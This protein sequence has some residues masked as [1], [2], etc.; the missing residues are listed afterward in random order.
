MSGFTGPSL[1]R[2]HNLVYYQAF[3]VSTLGKLKLIGVSPHANASLSVSSTPHSAPSFPADR[4][5]YLAHKARLRPSM[6]TPALSHSLGP[7]CPLAPFNA[8]HQISPPRPP[9]PTHLLQPPSQMRPRAPKRFKSSKRESIH[10]LVS[11]S[12]NPNVIEPPTAN[13]PCLNH[14][15]Q[16]SARPRS[17]LHNIIPSAAADA[18]QLET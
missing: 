16:S 17:I 10:R 11:S 6:I 2:S 15:A 1:T 13:I 3:F 8:T 14:H 7:L 18:P 9:Y 12:T 5:I 4:N